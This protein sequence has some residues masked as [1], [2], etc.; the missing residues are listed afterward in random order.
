MISK[1]IKYVDYNGIEKEETFWFNMSRTD[2]MRMEASE[3]GGWEE[4]LRKMIDEKDAYK[5]YLFFEQF[6][7][8]SYGVKTP[9]GGFDKDER[10]YKA[11][12][13][14]AAYDDFVWYFIEHPDEAGAFINGIVASIKKN[15]ASDKIDAIIAEQTQLTG[16]KVMD[17]V[18]PANP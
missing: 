9:S 11:F 10:H 8:E 18:T 14:S 15:D 13:S 3:N 5:A 7:K 1:T 12:R 2:L 17:F 16:S 6:I 4:R